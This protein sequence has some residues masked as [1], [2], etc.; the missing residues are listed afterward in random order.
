MNEEPIV[1]SAIS[2][3]LLDFGF[4]N[5]WVCMS[6]TS[7]RVLDDEEMK[8]TILS[9]SALIEML[10]GVCKLAKE[11]RKFSCSVHENKRPLRGRLSL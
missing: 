4:T 7:I 5:H 10:A 6:R 9:G 3:S 2:R 1:P 11:V 8:E